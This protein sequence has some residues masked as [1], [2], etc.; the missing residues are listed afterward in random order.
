M[1]YF[2]K[3]QTI[4]LRELQLKPLN[5]DFAMR[6]YLSIHPS[7]SPGVQPDRQQ[8]AGP[9]SCGPA[10]GQPSPPT[11]RTGAH[12]HRCEADER[13]RRTVDDDRMHHRSSL[14]GPPSQRTWIVLAEQRADEVITSACALFLFQWIIFFLFLSLLSSLFELS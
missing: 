14:I 1:Q 2:P 5:W 11:G 8:R 4:C 3:R 13:R 9:V 7:T 12:L 6:S 10:A